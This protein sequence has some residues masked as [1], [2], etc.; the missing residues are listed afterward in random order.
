[1]VGEERA[2]ARGGTWAKGHRR[3]GY[4]TLGPTRRTVQR[5]T[6]PNCIQSGPPG[7]RKIPEKSET[8]E[9]TVKRP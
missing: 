1:M 6:A 8:R 2:F 9:E 5:P 3:I 4:E 7:R